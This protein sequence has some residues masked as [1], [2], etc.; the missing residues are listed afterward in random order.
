MAHLRRPSQIAVDEEKVSRLERAHTAPAKQGRSNTHS[1][2]PWRYIPP[3]PRSNRDMSW[4]DY[5]DI[6]KTGDLIMFRTSTVQGALTRLV[7]G[8]S[9]D[10]IGVVL[11]SDGPGGKIC[12]LEA[13]SGSGVISNQLFLFRLNKWCDQYSSTIVR[14]LKP[15]LP[16]RKAQ[17]FIKF[18]EKAVGRGYS[19]LNAIW[20]SPTSPKAM[21]KAMNKATNQS[22]KLAV[23]KDTKG[24]KGQQP[25]KDYFCSELVASCY[26]EIGLLPGLTSCANYMPGNFLAS[27]NL[28]LMQGHSLGEE[29]SIK[30]RD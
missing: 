28:Q 4:I 12:I 7:T 15:P 5:Q 14:Q 27:F 26:R 24:A 16:Q 17:A 8:C 19:L 3:S 30:W 11:R 22:S 20:P 23:D 13:L 9:I 2:K 18:T 25:S 29:I 21:N 1:K 6:A 10:H